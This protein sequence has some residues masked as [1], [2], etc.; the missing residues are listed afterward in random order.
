MSTRT[1]R[2]E[3]GTHRGQAEAAP[4]SRGR[5][6]NGIVAAPRLWRRLSLAGYVLPGTR[7]DVVATSNYKWVDFH[8]GKW[9]ASDTLTGSRVVLRDIKV[10]KAP[11]APAAGP[12]GHGVPGPA[13]RR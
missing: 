13:S 2:P 6:R 3:L 5:V 7:V 8:G 9:Q 1:A 11:A 10:L 4:L 12:P